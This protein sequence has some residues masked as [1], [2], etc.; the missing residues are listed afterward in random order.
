MA[1]SRRQSVVVVLA[2]LAWLALIV[3]VVLTA[4]SGIGRALAVGRL[5]ALPVDVLLAFLL[6][7]LSLLRRAAAAE[8]RLAVVARSG[9][10]LWWEAD[11]SG[12]LLDAGELVEEYFGYRRGEVPALTLA[13]VVHPMEQARMAGLIAAGRGWS[14][15]RFR[16]V[17][18]QG[19]ERWVEGSAVVVTNPQTGRPDRVVGSCHPITS[20]VAEDR[21]LSGLLEEVQQL[22]GSDRLFTVFQPIVSVETGRMIGAEALARIAE[23]DRN[24][25]DWFAVAGEVGLTAH[26]EIHALRMALQASAALPGDIYL[27]VN[28]S[29]DTLSRPGTIELL[30]CNG[31]VEPSRLVVEITEHAAIECYDDIRDVIAQLRAHGLRVAIDDAGAGYSSFRHIIELTPEL[32]KLDRSLMIDIG[33]DQARRAFASATV[34]FA[35][36][37]GATVIAEGI[38]SI[39]ELRCAQTIGID[40]AQG[41]LFGR[42]TANWATWTEWHQRGPLYRGLV[43]NGAAPPVSDADLINA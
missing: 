24:V 27:S 7:R 42:P 28:L 17:T 12:R 29:P 36:E 16:C 6:G 11:A 3:Y 34:I 25:Q 43:T 21:R 41:Y 20:T 37:T 33:H 10:E 38:E 1:R 13:D 23:S 15:E 8:R 26:L 39:D 40:A 2:G 35:L 14:R 31:L 22:L 18:K 19:V 4:R 30:T 5:V 9:G 32:I